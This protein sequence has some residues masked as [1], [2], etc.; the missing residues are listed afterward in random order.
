MVEKTIQ[1]ADSVSEA[2]GFLIANKETAD[3]TFSTDIRILINK[4]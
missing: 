2:I 1:E 3:L 4:L